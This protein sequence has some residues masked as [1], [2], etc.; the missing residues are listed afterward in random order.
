MIAAGGVFAGGQIVIIHNFLG[1]GD[2]AANS[3]LL[4]GA[5]L[6]EPSVLGEATIDR[7][8]SAVAGIQ[9]GLL[10]TCSVSASLSGEAAV[11][12]SIGGRAS[13]DCECCS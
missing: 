12:A 9:F 4:C 8:L 7:D 10:G 2:T 3:V 5:A 13:I 6:I 11:S 1:G